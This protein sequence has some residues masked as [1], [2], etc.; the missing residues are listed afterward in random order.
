MHL[1]NSVRH[2]VSARFLTLIE[3]NASY[4]AWDDPCHR[5]LL[6]VPK[7][8]F[9]LTATVLGCLRYLE[10]NADCFSVKAFSVAH[11]MGTH[12]RAGE[13]GHKERCGSVVTTVV[14]GQS[15]YVRV[16][17]FLK[18]RGETCPGYA[19]VNWFAVPEYPFFNPLVV[20]VGDDGSHL[21]E[22]LGVVIKITSIDPSQV[23][24]GRDETN[25]VSYY[26]MRSSGY[27]TIANNMI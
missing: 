13:W 17:A 25:V 18:V 2:D 23:I 27:D 8:D 11:I 4:N 9:R 5:C 19:V 26:M 6:S 16:L 3:R 15:L 10:S 14:R 1:S 20:R 7:K 24:I 12:F 21:N 22:T